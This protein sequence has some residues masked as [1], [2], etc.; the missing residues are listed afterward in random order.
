MLRKKGA[1]LELHAMQWKKR[2]RQNRC[3]E[4]RERISPRKIYIL[5]RT[6]VNANGWNEEQNAWISGNRMK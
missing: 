3:T 6:R 1:D 2:T 5:V 4:T